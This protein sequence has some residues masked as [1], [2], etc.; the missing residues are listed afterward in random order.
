MSYADPFDTRHYRPSDDPEVE[1][2]QREQEAHDSELRPFA[3]GLSTWQPYQR[4]A[5]Y[6]NVATLAEVM[7]ARAIR[8]AN[9]AALAELRKL[10][11]ER[12]RTAGVAD[13][14]LIR[15]KNLDETQYSRSGPLAW[16]DVQSTM[17]HLQRSAHTHILNLTLLTDVRYLRAQPELL[18]VP[19]PEIVNAAN[20]HKPYLCLTAELRQRVTQISAHEAFLRLAARRL[21]N[22]S[23]QALIAEA[24]TAHGLRL[25]AVLFRYDSTI[26]LAFQLDRDDRFFALLTLGAHGNELRDK[27]AAEIRAALSVDT[28]QDRATIGAE[29]VQVSAAQQV[30]ARF[31]GTDLDVYEAAY[32]DFIGVASEADELKKIGREL[33]ATERDAVFGHVPKEEQAK[34]MRCCTSMIVFTPA[35]SKTL[36]SVAVSAGFG[37]FVACQCTLPAREVERYARAYETAASLEC[38]RDL[39][40]L[41]AAHMPPLIA[42]KRTETNKKKARIV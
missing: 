6:N 42:T 2:L 10:E 12:A 36:Q 19:F 30:A 37:Y 22:I 40:T 27:V 11:A 39:Q 21:H 31:K 1:K 29:A 16:S 25:H 17:R 13:V 4:L 5:L 9:P 34:L 14:T 26:E 24:E 38:I 18:F 20:P 35:L 41:D 8:P 33:D 32:Y 3:A 28:S 7:D 15:V 23:L